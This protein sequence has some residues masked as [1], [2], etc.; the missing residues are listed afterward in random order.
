MVVLGVIELL[1]TM[2]GFSLSDMSARTSRSRPTATAPRRPVPLDQCGTRPASDPDHADAWH[3]FDRGIFPAGHRAQRRHL[4]A[5]FDRRR[6]RRRRHHSGGPGHQPRHRTH[7]PARRDLCGRRRRFRRPGRRWS[8]SVR[9]TRDCPAA[10]VSR[11]SSATGTPCRRAPAP[12]RKRSRSAA[13]VL[14]VDRDAKSFIAIA[15][16]ADLIAQQQSSDRASTCGNLL[17]PSLSASLLICHHRLHVRDAVPALDPRRGLCPHRPRRPESRARRRLRRAAGLPFDGGGQSEDAAA[18]SRPRR[19][20]FADHQGPHAR[21]HRRRILRP[22]QTRHVVD[23]A[24]RADARQPHQRRRR[25]ARTDRGE[26]RR[27]PALG[28]RH[29]ASRRAAG[30]ARDLRQVGAGRGRRRHPEQRPRA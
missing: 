13:S 17:Y 6:R 28:R 21:R 16:P 29:H 7:H 23:R 12:I 4:D 26:I 30:T 19:A 22:R 10:S 20:G 14:L 5:G 24:G 11:M 18:G 15:A 8:R 2:V 1:S 3:L 9:S 27:R 25:T